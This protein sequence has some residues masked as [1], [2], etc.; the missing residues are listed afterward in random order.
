MTEEDSGRLARSSNAVQRDDPLFPVTPA[1]T[2]VRHAFG[3][4]RRATTR[5]ITGGSPDG[6][7][8]SRH[9][10]GRGAHLCIGDFNRTL[11]RIE[12][13]RIAKQRPVAVTTH[14]GDDRRHA[15]FRG[16]VARARRRKQRLNGPSISRVNDFHARPRSC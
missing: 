9:L 10:S 12:A 3:T 5:D 4:W 14:G 7:H 6:A 13:A 11:E 1:A 2:R 16:R 15:A 8:R